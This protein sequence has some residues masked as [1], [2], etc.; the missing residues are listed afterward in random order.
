MKQPSVTSALPLR[1]PNAL[2][3]AIPA[4]A[5]A[6]GLMLWARSLYQIRTLPERVMEWSLQF[7][8]LDLFEQ[9]LQKFGTSAK[10]IA[11][12]GNY[13]GLALTLVV[14]GAIA[15]R[16]GARLIAG[17]SLG[18]WLFAMVVVMPITGAGFF[19]SDLA[20]D[21]ILTDFSYLAL[22]LAYGTVLLLTHALVTS[23]S[24]T[25][26]IASGSLESRRAFVGALVGTGAAYALTFWFGRNAGASNSTLPLASVG[27]LPTAVPTDTAVAAPTQLP[28][29][30]TAPAPGA[31]TPG[32][33]GTSAAEANAALP[34]ATI[35]PPATATAAPTATPL[36]GIPPRPAPAQAV[37]RDKDGSL[38]AS[39]QQAGQVATQFTPSNGF[40]ITTKNAGGDPIVDP[41]KWRLVLDGEVANPIQLDLPILYKL[42]SVQV[43]KT[44]ECISNWVNKCEQVPF[45]CGLIGN[46]AWKG[47]R[48][49]DVLAVAGGLKPGVVGIVTLA[50]DEF[51]SFIPADPTLLHDTLLVYEMNGQV[52]PLEHGY[53]AR[54]L[55]PGRYGM[56]SPKW[57]IGIRPSKTVIADWYGKLGWSKDGIV[58]AMTRI[59]VPSTGA[60]LPA[61][62]QQIGGIAYAGSRGVS[63]VEFSADGG[64]TW[65][66][67]AFLEDPPGKDTWV[68]WQGTFT[69]PSSGT[70]T[71]AARCVDGNGTPQNTNYT[72]TQPNGG[73]GLNTAV[74]KAA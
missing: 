19:A 21:I 73:T 62:Q 56:K 55:V 67:A 12:L 59:D 17:L 60:A 40:Y 48:L 69:M 57:V 54:L 71:L 11:L 64:Q 70:L 74:V 42:P 1:W 24:A 50:V 28:T 20:Q 35:A 23:G 58:Q 49:T 14:I 66:K 72:I 61:G 36:N 18:L 7:I 41:D 22:A 51:S 4:T 32:L 63:K 45:G 34:T 37:K 10:E 39:T 26:A 43:V 8:P 31:A 46:A 30:T 15:L 29:A 3:L 53:P 27:N 25:V 2:A 65:S 68:R 44:L 33:V 52:L 6:L 9:G 16:S 13:L 5:V 47:A 38:T